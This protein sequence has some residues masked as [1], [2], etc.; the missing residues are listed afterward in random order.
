M[1]SFIDFISEDKIENIKNMNLDIEH[2]SNYQKHKLK[3]ILKI[4]D[5]H[6]TEYQNMVNNGYLRVFDAGNLVMVYEAER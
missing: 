5:E 2:R 3:K 6:L 4:F 1:K